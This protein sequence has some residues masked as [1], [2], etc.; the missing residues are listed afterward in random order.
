MK[1]KKAMTMET[2]FLI[3][4]VVGGFVVFYVSV[5]EAKIVIPNYIGE[6]Q[7][8]IIKTAND[9]EKALLYI[10]HSSKY[11]AQQAAYELAKKGGIAVSDCGQH[12]GYSVWIDSSNKNCNPGNDQLSGSFGTTLNDELLKYLEIYPGALIPSYYDYKLSGNLDIVGISKENLAIRIVPDNFVFRP[13]ITSKNPVEIYE[14]SQQQAPEL[15]LE[16]PKKGVDIETIKKYHPEVLVQYEELCKR[17][18]IKEP[19]GICTSARKKCCITDGYRHPSRNEEVG[20]ARTSAHQYGLALDLH[21]GSLEEQYKVVEANEKQPKLF[22]RIGVY[23]GDAHIH[24]D[25][26]PLQG[27]YAVPFFVARG[28]QTLATAGNIA[29]L[30]NK[31]NKFT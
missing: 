8:A 11:S 1:T 5:L 25:L 20:G 28:G 30:K 9:A 4:A 21:I 18:G 27:S 17:I 22:T 13:A 10:E 3:L 2:A 7:F 24:V 29:D 12:Y 23:P 26:M 15:I 16:S 31:A 19:P 6:H 14:E